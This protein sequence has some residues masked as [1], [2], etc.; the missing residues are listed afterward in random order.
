M[1]NIRRLKKGEIL[2]REGEVCQAVYIV[3]SGKLALNVERGGRKLEIMTLGTSQLVGEQSI[4]GT[5]KHQ[6]TAEAMQETKV[7]EV[8][9]ELMKNQFSG[10]SGGIKLLIKSLVEESK[11]SRTMLRSLKMETD[12][13]PCPQ[14]S[15]PR[16]FSMLNLVARH[17]GV[18]AESNDKDITLDW[19]VLKLYVA[20]M[21]AESQQRMRSLLDLLMKLGYADLTIET[22]EDGEEELTKIRIYNI[23][24]VE[25]F[26]EFYQYNLYKGTRA[27]IIYLDTLA[28]KVGKALVLLSVDQEPDRR[29]AVTLEYDHILEQIRSRFKFELKSTHLDALEKKGLFVKRSSRDDGKVYLSFDKAEFEKTVTFWTVIHEIDKW[30]E[31]GFVNLHEKEEDSEDAN[32]E[33]CPQ[34]EGKINQ[35]HRFCPHCGFKLAA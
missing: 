23:Q 33:S 19:S 2:F 30:N 17:T 20:R 16:I 26:S 1:D 4:F 31:L 15:I 18:K 8:P 24:L 21:F 10:C 28:F 7:M 34:C 35:D 14:V 9:V 25:D 5:A 27:E 3:Q 22:D 13:S 11:Q 6:F 12:K 32:A 29:G